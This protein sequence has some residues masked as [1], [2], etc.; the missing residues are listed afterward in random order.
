MQA[1]SLGSR[2]FVQHC[3]PGLLISLSGKC[4]SAMED[5]DAI[6]GRIPKK[7]SF[8]FFIINSYSIVDY[9]L[10]KND[11]S[12]LNLQL[13]RNYSH[14]EHGLI[15]SFNHS[16][17]VVE[18]QIHVCTLCGRPCMCGLVHVCVCVCGVCVCVCACMRACV[19]AC[20]CVCV[21]G[22]GWVDY[23]CCCHWLL[24]FPCT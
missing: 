12:I 17:N 14:Y 23:P 24:S 11:T 21:W 6:K 8:S 16:F 15:R 1:F 2:P 19:C 5:S 20:V 9:V 13:E 4:P 10:Y 22:G 18:S 7:T 3:I